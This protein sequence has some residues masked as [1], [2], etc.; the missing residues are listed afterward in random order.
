[1]PQTTTTALRRAIATLLRR[2]CTA[3]L[4]A[5]ALGAAPLAAKGQRVNPIL[6][7]PHAPLVTRLGI[8]DG[9]VT[10]SALRP[11]TL[12]EVSILGT[13]VRIRTGDSGRFRFVDVPAGRHVLVVRHGASRPLSALVEVVRADTLR[14]HYTV[15]TVPQEPEEAGAGARRATRPVHASGA[16]GAPAV[17]FALTQDQIEQHDLPM[18][19]DYLRLAPGVTLV[20]VPGATGFTDLVAFGPREA[21]AAARPDAEGCAMQVLVDDVP[22]PPRFPLALLPH[23]RDLARIEVHAGEARGSGPSGRPDPACGSIVI[24]T[25]RA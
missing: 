7:A 8:I 12:A 25:K 6:G 10:D 20:P 16:R 5:V 17:G 13:D 22:M 9:T 24:R 21:N 11:V 18:S 14:V 19:A 2:A 1:M 3:A 23:P 4:V 15:E